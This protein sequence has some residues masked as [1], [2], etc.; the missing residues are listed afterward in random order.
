MNTTFGK[1]TGWDN[2]AMPALCKLW[3]PGFAAQRKQ[4][5]FYMIIIFKAIV[6]ACGVQDPVP[7]VDKIQ[8]PTV[9]FCGQLNVQWD[10]PFLFFIIY[11][12]VALFYY[13]YDEKM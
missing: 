9:F 2:L 12:T 5:T 1:C 3:H 7:D 13:I 8:Q 11:A 4:L 6:A 10:A